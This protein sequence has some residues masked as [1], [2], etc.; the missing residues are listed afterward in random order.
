[1]A[2]IKANATYEGMFLF[3]GA[4][5]SD[6]ESALGAARLTIE[7]H[8]G[9]IIVLK[10]WDERKLTYE[11]ERNKRGVYVI[12]YFTAPGTAVV[13]IERDVLLSDN[14][15]RVMITR[16]DHLNEAEMNAVEPQPIIKEERPSWDRG[17]SG[18]FEGGGGGG[19]RSGGYGDRPP[20]SDKPRREEPAMDAKD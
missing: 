10:K 9:T 6:L 2:T 4:T 14:I 7:R 19:G 15:L 13:G 3:P 12:A 5:A 17:F 8:G 18:G 20:R 1:M 11:I 16:A